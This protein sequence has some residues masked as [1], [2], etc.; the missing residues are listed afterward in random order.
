MQAMTPVRLGDATRSLA[1]VL[2]RPGGTT[3]AANA[4]LLCPPFGQE[5]IRSHRIFRVIA[6]R[7]ARRGHWALRFD[8][9]G[10]GDSAGD[11]LDADLGGWSDDILTASAW[12]ERQSQCRRQIWL[13]ARLGATVAI[14]TAQRS[15]TRAPPLVIAWEPV[16]NGLTYLD[17]L[18]Q[19]HRA[20]LRSSYS[21]PDPRWIAQGCVEDPLQLREAMGFAVS[22]RWVSQVSAVGTQTLPD[23]LPGGLICIEGPD[24][25]AFDWT[26]EEAI[27]GALV[28][29][30][31]LECVLHAV[32]AS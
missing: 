18:A 22:A 28:P 14:Q 25:P 10:S 11:D 16:R 9:F 4:V 3:A 2:H 7:L 20:A 31:A 1:A 17:E 19:H 32:E 27:N 15:A 12:L 6:D 24:R 26:A 21:L 30:T 23:T 8:Y 13:G 5:A 29:A